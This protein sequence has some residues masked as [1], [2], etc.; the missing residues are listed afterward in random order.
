MQAEVG[1]RVVDV[2]A[3]VLGVVAAVEGPEPLA[4]V[5]V[6]ITSFLSRFVFPHD[7]DVRLDEFFLERSG[8]AHE[9]FDCPG[10]VLREHGGHGVPLGGKVKKSKI[11]LF[12]VDVAAPAVVD[13][14]VFVF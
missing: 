2:V 12:G 3:V 9:P 4:V 6:N 5:V 10:V 8:L 11:I 1:L 7:K 14:G 13:G